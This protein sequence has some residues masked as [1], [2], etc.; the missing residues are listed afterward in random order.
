MKTDK[1]P[2]ILCGTDFSE[3][4]AQAATVAGVLAARMTRP[5]LLV[6]VADEFNAHAESEKTLDRFLQPVRKQLQVEVERM[7]KAGAEVE[8]ELV[9]GSEAEKALTELAGRRLPALVVVSAV[10]KT[11]FDRWTIGS[12]SETL[13]E[14][15]AAATLVVRA[16]APFEAWARGERPLKVFVAADFTNLSEAPLRWVRELRRAGPCEITVAYA[17]KPPEERQRL[18]VDAVAHTEDS[19]TV[20]QVLERGLREK[21]RTQLGDE[22]VRILIEPVLDHPDARLIGLAVEAEADVIVVGTRQRHGL[23]RLG[24][25]SVSRGILRHA[26]MNVICVPAAAAAQDSARIPKV[27]RVLVATDF[28]ELADQAVPH[29][30]SLVREGGTVVLV[31]VTRPMRWPSV[32]GSNVESKTNAARKAHTATLR[33]ATARLQALIPDEAGQR[34]IASEVHVL[35]RT[36]PAKA[37]YQAAERFGADVICLGSHG[38]SGLSAALVGSVTHAVMEQTLRPVLVVRPPAE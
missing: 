38:R 15:V 14:S 2:P 34:G 21:V 36:A 31:H 9:H 28:S 18:G 30:Y 4:A 7:R 27:E 3:N 37:I 8:V 24:H 25:H 5:L 23:D 33:A 20:Q 12:V 11:A 32:L 1:T 13:A 29:A 16:A 22:E 19:P 26:P 10:S 6:H 17:N 35:E